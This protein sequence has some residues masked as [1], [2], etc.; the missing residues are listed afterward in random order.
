M[1]SEERLLGFFESFKKAF[2]F[3]ADH[4]VMISSTV[5]IVFTGMCYFYTA[6]YYSMFGIDF[7]NFGSLSDVYQAALTGKI[8]YYALIPV[9]FPFIAA[10]S[11]FQM[12]QRFAVNPSRL[13]NSSLHLFFLVTILALFPFIIFVTTPKGEEATIKQGFAARYTLY[14]ENGKINCLPIIASTGNYIVVWDGFLDEAKIISRASVIKFDLVVEPPP[15]KV[16]LPLPKAQDT[17]NLPLPEYYEEQLRWLEKLNLKCGPS[18][19]W[20]TPRPVASS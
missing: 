5:F 7:Y 11:V 6:S 15:Y 8:L 14:T 20:F 2:R 10:F 1:K 13:L 3:Y 18:S 17:N 19:D 4:Y 12:K 9:V 16:P